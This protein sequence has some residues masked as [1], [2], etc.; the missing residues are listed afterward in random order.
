MNDYADSKSG[1]DWQDRK[2]YKFFGGSK[3]IQEGILSEQFY[4]KSAIF[5]F[6][7]A[8]ICISLL[9]AVFKGISIFCFYILILFLGF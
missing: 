4:L 5:C 7:L 2:F 3:L 8:F 9:A 6:I 1:V